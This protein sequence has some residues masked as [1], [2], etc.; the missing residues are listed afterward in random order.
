M[1]SR[2]S[3]S[4]S[5]SYE[6]SPVYDIPAFYTLQPLASSREKQLSLWEN[7]FL[8]YYSAKET[9]CISLPSEQDAPLF[10]NASI[11]RRISGSLLVALLQRLQE[12]RR[13]LQISESE[14]VLTFK[15]QDV[16]LG[17]DDMLSRA[18]AHI[19]GYGGWQGERFVS[20]KAADEQINLSGSRYSEGCLR[21][22]F[23]SA[24]LRDRVWRVAAS[25]LVIFTVS[26][27]QTVASVQTAIL[28]ASRWGSVVGVQDL[29]RLLTA[30]RWRLVR[31]ADPI[32][33]GRFYDELHALGANRELDPGSLLVKSY[34]DSQLPQLL[35][36]HYTRQETGG[37]YSYAD[38]S[39][40]LM[41]WMRPEQWEFIV[42]EILRK[43][44][45]SGRNSVCTTCGVSTTEKRNHIY[46]SRLSLEAW[47]DALVTAGDSSYP[48]GGIYT[49]RQLIELLATA[50]FGV[51]RLT[52]GLVKAMIAAHERRDGDRARLRAIEGLEDTFA[53]FADDIDS[54]RAIGE[55]IF[56]HYRA[57]AA[58]GIK[59]AASGKVKGN[60]GEM[61]VKY[62][63]SFE[64][65]PV[66]FVFARTAGGIQL[67]YARVPYANVITWVGKRFFGQTDL[68]VK[69]S[70]DPSTFSVEGLDVLEP[71]SKRPDPLY[72]YIRPAEIESKESEASP[73]E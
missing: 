65:M 54:P 59:L 57:L 42:S 40:E 20:L 68:V 73:S 64:G 31:N 51:V 4:S 50:R 7:E 67:L 9:L 60:V 48:W 2:S 33:A 14:Y 13:I 72:M 26:A 28:S 22:L 21:Y 41:P 61:T 5:S 71:G 66:L 53:L 27:R 11:K 29:V 45:P 17:V 63:Y 43:F 37:V 23:A 44:A 10:V 39:S 6:F 62:P 52:A 16:S 38:V 30:K 32:V 24:S 15:S 18:S 49:T 70:L 69:I 47:G 58:T 25:Y 46:L 3:S 1:S 55:E 56:N 8:R 19:L 36:E 35:V 34:E 12:R